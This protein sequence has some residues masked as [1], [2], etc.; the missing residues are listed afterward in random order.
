MCSDANFFIVNIIFYE[1]GHSSTYSICCSAV[2]IVP[3]VVAKVGVMRIFKI[4]FLKAEYVR[5][6]FIKNS[7]YINRSFVKSVYIPLNNT[8]HE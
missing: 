5:V 1:C 8:G 7:V 6:E 4:C 2:F 3:C